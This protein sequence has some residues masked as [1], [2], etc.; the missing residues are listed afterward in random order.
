MTVKKD[1][2]LKFTAELRKIGI[3]P[4]VFLPDDLLH[5]IFKRAQKNKGPIAVTVKVNKGNEQP[6]TLLRYKGEWRLYINTK[7]LPGSPQRTGELLEIAIALDSSKREPEPHPKFI[8]ALSENPEAKDVFNRL[9]PSLQKEIIKYLSFL[10]TEKSLNR[11]IERALQFLLGKGSFVGRKELPL[12][13]G[14]QNPSC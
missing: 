3:N 1:S 5:E 6:Q 10:K 13:A 12:P 4:F 7:I 14:K 11:N 8:A 2:T 9:Q